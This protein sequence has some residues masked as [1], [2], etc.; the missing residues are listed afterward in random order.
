MQRTLAAW[1]VALPVAAGG[2]LVA[3]AAAYALAGGAGRPSHAYLPLAEAGVCALLAL[4]VAAAALAART[5]ALARPRAI[6][7]ALAPPLAFALQETAERGFAP[8]LDPVVLLGLVLQLPFALLAYVAARLL[9]RA[10][11][12][13]VRGPAPVRTPDRTPR[14]ATGL[15]LPPA[16]VPVARRGRAPPPATAS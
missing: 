15:P 10:V 12:A 11:E 14:A 2:V 13:L 4:G 16:A 6:A 1:L 8:P 7:F 5:A 9:L 3:H